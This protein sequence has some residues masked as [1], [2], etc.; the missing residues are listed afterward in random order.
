[1]IFLTRSPPSAALSGGAAKVHGW[2]SLPK[3]VSTMVHPGAILAI[4]LQQP[5]VDGQ[6][7]NGSILI[8]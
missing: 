5:Q 1:M 3:P 2:P 7:L 4:I 8:Q 6:N